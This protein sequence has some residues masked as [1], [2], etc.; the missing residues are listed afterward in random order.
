MAS[1]EEGEMMAD[2]KS[3]PPE[4]RSVSELGPIIEAHYVRP[5][6]GAK[7]VSL[8]PMVLHCETCNAN[9]TP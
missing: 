3:P 2:Q 9:Y 7:F 1:G 6:C 4:K 5:Q 8:G